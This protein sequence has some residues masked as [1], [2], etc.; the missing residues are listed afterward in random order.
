MLN[1]AGIYRTRTAGVPIT[2][3]NQHLKD[4][5]GSYGGGFLNCCYGTVLL[6]KKDL[7]SGTGENPERIEEILRILAR[8]GFVTLENDMVR[9]HK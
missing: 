1:L 7:I 4:L 8:E 9:L 2:T 6:A 3:G 5:I